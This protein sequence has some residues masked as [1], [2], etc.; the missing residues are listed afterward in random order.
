MKGC[1]WDYHMDHTWTI[2]TMMEMC[3]L[4]GYANQTVLHDLMRQRYRHNRITSHALTI[5]L[6]AQQPC[7]MSVRQSCKPTKLAVLDNAGGD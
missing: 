2:T 5:A 7:F 6:H 4:T 1:V 3:R